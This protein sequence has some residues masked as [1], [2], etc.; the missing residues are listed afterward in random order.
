MLEKLQITYQYSFVPRKRI[1]VSMIQ[2]RFQGTWVIPIKSQET[3][4]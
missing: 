3:P 4:S 2:T 1:C